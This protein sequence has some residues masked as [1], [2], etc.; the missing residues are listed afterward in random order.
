MLTKSTDNG[1]NSAVPRRGVY[2][3]TNAPTA[4]PPGALNV[5]PM[6]RQ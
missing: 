1:V 6:G 3:S 2:S 4:R 5:N